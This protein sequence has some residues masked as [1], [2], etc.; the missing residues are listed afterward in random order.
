MKILKA[1]AALPYIQMPCG[2]HNQ[3]IKI[4]PCEVGNIDPAK[5]TVRQIL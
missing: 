1:V 3:G 4:R 5:E 2:Y